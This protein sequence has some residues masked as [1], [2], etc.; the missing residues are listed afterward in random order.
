MELFDR[1]D[2]SSP[3]FLEHYN[4]T[5]AEDTPLDQE[6]AVDPEMIGK[7]YESLVNIKFE[8]KVETDQRGEAGIFYTPRVEIDLMCRLALTDWLTNHLGKEYKT[9]IRRA[10]CAYFHDEKQSADNALLNA[11]LIRRIYDLLVKI[12]VLD[13]AC[14]SGSFLV[15][16]LLVLDNLLTRLSRILGV[17]ETSYERRKLIIGQSLYGVDVMDWAVH[18]A[19]LRLWL[20]LVVE[21]DLEPAELRF[22]PLL[23]NLS[24]KVR[25]GDSLVQEIAGV[26]FWSTSIPSRS[27][28]FCYKRSFKQADVNTV[29]CL[30]SAPI[31]GRNA[32]STRRRLSELLY[33]ARFAMFKV[34]F[35]YALSPVVFEEIDE[36]TDRFRRP[37]FRVVVRKQEDLL[38]EGL[39]LPDDENSPDIALQNR[40][41]TGDKWGGKYLRAPDIFY[42]ILEKGNGKLVS[43]ARY[44][45]F[46]GYIHDNNVGKKYPST[47]VVL[48]SQFINKIDVSDQDEF[49][50]REGIK[51]EGNS[52]LVPDIVIPR[53]YNDTFLAIRNPDRV[54]FKR[55]YKVLVSDK[56]MIEKIC[57]SLNATM[58]ILFWEYI[59]IV[60]GLGAL[61]VYKSDFARILILD[62]KLF[63]PETIISKLFTTREIH[64]IIIECGFDKGRPLRGQNPNPLP[65]RKALDDIIFDVLGLTQV[66]RN[67][68]YYAVCE[69]VQNRLNKARSV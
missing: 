50:V 26:Q 56:N 65:D 45:E 34:P 62:V 13:P 41:D 36:A 32:V 52:R 20:Q 1:F 63:Q 66:E 30:F 58:Q 23:P 10:V 2:N 57:L 60:A 35:E 42:T 31:A 37:E 44:A 49:V 8:G 17:E 33:N 15:G 7:V 38:E 12:T 11:N 27:I 59:G 6:V 48:S 3:G 40:S 53:T 68:A 16:M 14:G 39:G 55:F 21:T 54:L 4:F 29:I 51:K 43:L 25:C 28:R 5:V 18:V 67:E 47:K 69:L 19:E 64:P 22:R 61:N 24:F 9:L 46:A